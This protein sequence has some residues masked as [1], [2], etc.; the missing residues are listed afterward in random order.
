MWMDGPLWYATYGVCCSLRLSSFWHDLNIESSRKELNLGWFTISPP[1][2]IWKA[3]CPKFM[4]HVAT[5]QDVILFLKYFLTFYFDSSVP[6]SYICNIAKPCFWDKKK[7]THTHKI[8]TK[9]KSKT[10]LKH[11]IILLNKICGGLQLFI[12][13]NHFVNFL[14]FLLGVRSRSKIS[15]LDSY[16]WNLRKVQ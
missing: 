9:T 1:T 12:I 8:K 14:S 10:L 11:V 5:I 4:Q 3:N 6:I 13:Y 2:K 15:Y 7:H 16:N